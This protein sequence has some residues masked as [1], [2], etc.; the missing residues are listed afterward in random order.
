MAEAPAQAYDYAIAQLIKHQLHDYIARNL[1]KQ[2]PWQCNYYGS[3]EVGRWLWEILSQG[4]TRVWRQL[5]R[6]KTGEDLSS[7]AML[8]YYEPLRAYLEQA[9]AGK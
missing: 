6:E 8:A 4:A 1:L 2:S 7:R 5:L 9:G 3:R